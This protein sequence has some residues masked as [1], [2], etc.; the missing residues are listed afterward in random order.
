[1][2]LVI[3]TM[4]SIQT[5]YVCKQTTFTKTID[6]HSCKRRLI[7]RLWIRLFG[8]TLCLSFVFFCTVFH[9]MFWYISTLTKNWLYNCHIALCSQIKKIR[10]QCLFCVISCLSSELLSGHHI[11]FMISSTLISLGFY[12]G[13]KE[14]NACE[15]GQRQKLLQR[16]T[17][18]FCHISVF[19]TNDVNNATAIFI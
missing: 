10:S 16:Y 13:D 11:F 7:F 17:F 5:Q 19:R 2:F 9:V 14:R 4:T 6:C 15:D 1:M 8:S 12:D 18:G 3:T